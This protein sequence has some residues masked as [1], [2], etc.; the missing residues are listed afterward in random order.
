MIAVQRILNAEAQRLLRE[1]DGDA[2][3]ATP[4]RNPHLIDGSPDDP[5]PRI[6]TQVVEVLHAQRKCRT[7]AA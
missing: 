2:A 3:K 6:E 7:E 1:A 5:S 4:W